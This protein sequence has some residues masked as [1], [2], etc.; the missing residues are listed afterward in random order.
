[1][2]TALQL[3][4]LIDHNLTDTR[5]T[6]FSIVSAELATWHEISVAP[7]YHVNDL[8]VC[9]GRQNGGGREGVP[10]WKNELEQARGLFL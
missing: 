1:M 10:G 3:Q 4:Y 7:F 8:S 2:D 5:W 6:R 9:L